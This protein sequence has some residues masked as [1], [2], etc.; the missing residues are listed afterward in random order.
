MSHAFLSGIEW[1]PARKVAGQFTHTM[2]IQ[3][4]TFSDLKGAYEYLIEEA[5]DNGL[6]WLAAFF[7]RLGSHIDTTM[8]SFHKNPLKYLTAIYVVRSDGSIVRSV[9]IK[10]SGVLLGSDEL[11]ISADVFSD[12][13]PA[14]FQGLFTYHELGKRIVEETLTKDEMTVVR[15][16]LDRIQMN[17]QFMFKIEDCY[18]MRVQLWTPTMERALDIL[19]FNVSQDNID[20][21]SDEEK[22]EI[23]EA[24]LT[25]IVIDLR[26]SY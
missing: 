18:T 10:G 6:P 20:D 22:E 15:E 8:C 24:G 2:T 7:F 12:A 9:Q 11:C 23:R 13:K 1:K 3:R 25:Q 26:E 4:E 17:A 5:S 16:I 21:M 14:R 19:G